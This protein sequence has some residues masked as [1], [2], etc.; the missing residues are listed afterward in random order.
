MQESN[1]IIFTKLNLEIT[2]N[3]QQT[4]HVYKGSHSLIT[5]SAYT[6][7]KTHTRTRV[8]IHTHTYA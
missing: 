8:H 7:A 4:M 5:A 2:E 3:E 1:T 6:H